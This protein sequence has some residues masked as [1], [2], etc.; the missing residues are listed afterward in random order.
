MR[1]QIGR[2]APLTIDL[3]GRVTHASH[4]WDFFKPN[5]SSEYPEVNGTLSQKCYLQAL[6]DCY[7]K[8]VAKNEKLGGPATSTET[9][10]H[11]LFHTPYNK[12]VQKALGRLMYLDILNCS[13]EGNVPAGFKWKGIPSE[14]TFENRE[15]EEYMK[16]ASNE[17]YTR[18]V[19][20]SCTLSKNIGN[21]YTASVY[22]NLAELVSANGVD[23][24]SKSILLFSY[25][26][27]SMASLFRIIP[28]EVSHTYTLERMQ[29]CL[30]LSERLSL[31]IQTKPHVLNLALKAREI[32]SDFVPFHPKFPTS[33]LLGGTYYL[34]EITPN[35]ERIYERKQHSTHWSE[36]NLMQHSISDI[37]TALSISDPDAPPPPTLNG[38]GLDSVGF[39]TKGGLK[40]VSSKKF[41]SN[42]GM[43]RNSTY[44]WASG[45]PN[46]NIVVTGVSAAVPGRYSCALKPGVDSIQ[47]IINGEN[48]IT[49]LPQEVK[50]DM[51]SKNVVQLRKCKDGSTQKIPITSYEESINLCASIG[52]F[53]LRVYGVSE[54]IVNTMDRSV[55]VAV[56]AGLEALKDAGIVCGEGEG[57]SGWV[58][59]ES[60]QNSTG[61]VYATSFPALDAAIGEV[62]KYFTTKTLDA[63]DPISII[64]QLRGRLERALGDTGALSQE[65]EKALSDLEACLRDAPKDT[66]ESS[67]EFDRKFLF[68]VLVLG[69]AQ[70][71]QIIRARGPNMQTNA[72]CAGATQAVALAYDM[73]QVG[74]A[75]RMIII[76][77]DNASSDNLMPWLG[78]GFRALGAATKCSDVSMAALPFD[79]RRTGMILGSGGIGMVLESE[80]GAERRFA[81]SSNPLRSA[82]FRCR[83]MGTL[84]SNS[85]F[86]GASM[87]KNHIGQEMERFISS[88]EQEHGI[89]RSEI[90]RNGVYFS[91]ETMTHATPTASCAWNELQ[92]LRQ[93]FKDDLQYLLIC[94]T[95]GFTGHPMGVSFEDVV[96]SEVLVSGV[97]PPVAN[98]S[99]AD[100]FLG[101]DIKLSRGGRYDC[102][103]ALRFAAG[104]G[105]QVALALYGKA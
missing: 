33:H 13:T 86:H 99:E 91:H 81:L 50:D 45:R 65:T 41:G 46:I 21:T 59:P 54:S 36:I 57:L 85:A 87:D 98:D 101:T 58:L 1:F 12:L 42:L 78:N 96:A 35:F 34:K 31:R 26:S 69:N 10:D 16:T 32:I 24:M 64:A 53:D 103:Y 15:I 49:E 56:A 73:I 80:Q 75:E 17:L 4:A 39:I 90:A 48:F 100:P 93:V 40:K 70:L 30:S 44:I 67:Y 6:E 23:L 52:E 84:I 29:Q 63:K 14:E 83:L 88:I 47:R 38:N 76:A 102:K 51:L 89:T 11:I 5:L 79:K 28:R 61:I 66:V 9:C 22:I 105:S 74:R 60:L 27:G 68:R 94:N 7:T 25:G 19:L 18:K 37:E 43:T 82:P 97:V 3:R 71:A 92:G 72:A 77:G 95:K 20:P 62:S 2:D 8:F 55:Q 104:F